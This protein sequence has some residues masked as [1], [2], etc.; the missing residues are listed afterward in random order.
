MYPICVTSVLEYQISVFQ[1]TASHFR[2]TGHLRQVHRMT[3]QWPW[4]PQGRRHSTYVSAPYPSPKFQAVLLY[5]QQFSRYCTFSNPPLTTTLNGQKRNKKKKGPKFKIA[6]FTILLTT[7]VETLPMSIHEFWVS[8]VRYILSEEMPFETF[9]PVWSHVNE[10]E[11]NLPKIQNLNKKFT[12]LWTTL[13]ETK[14]NAFFGGS[15]SDV[16]F[17]RRWCLKFSLPYGAILTETK[18]KL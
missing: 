2:V 9:N 5:D 16:Y 6:F 3:P 14:E 8:I 15:E 11:T 10:N 17:Q 4:T 13:V 12:I 7:L 1:S 18:R